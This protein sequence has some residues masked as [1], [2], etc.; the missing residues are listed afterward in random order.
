MPSTEPILMKLVVAQ[1]HY[2]QIVHELIFSK[3]DI[4]K[5]SFA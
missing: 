4:V 3:L 5:Q 2:I 1:Q